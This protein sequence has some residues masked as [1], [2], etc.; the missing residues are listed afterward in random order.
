MQIDFN[1]DL[2]STGIV[3]YGT[4]SG[5]L[6]LVQNTSTLDGFHQSITLTGLTAATHYY[7]TVEGS[8]S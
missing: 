6:N 7:Y 1:T 5:N 2:S 3:H 8:A 4:S